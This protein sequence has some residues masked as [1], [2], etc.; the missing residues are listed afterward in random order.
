MEPE[1]P[2]FSDPQVSPCWWSRK[3]T[4]SSKAL[5]HKS[6]THLQHGPSPPFH[7]LC[8]NHQSN[9]ARYHL[10][11]TEESKDV[12]FSVLSGSPGPSPGLLVLSPQPAG[13][14]S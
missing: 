1:F 2:H 8:H 12:L 9:P 4:L 7:G 5:K 3:D 11:F 13:L 6:L 10:H 14:L